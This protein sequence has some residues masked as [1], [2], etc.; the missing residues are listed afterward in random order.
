MFYIITTHDPLLHVGTEE[1]SERDDLP[2]GERSKK[3]H[4]SSRLEI[5]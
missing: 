2:E 5:T 1:E 3:G 4:V